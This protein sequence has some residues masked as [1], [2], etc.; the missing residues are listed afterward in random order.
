MS[1]ARTKTHVRFARNV[2]CLVVISSLCFVWS[3]CKKEASSAT[4]VKPPSDEIATAKVELEPIATVPTPPVAKDFS[5][6]NAVS[7]VFGEGDEENGLKHRYQEKDGLTKKVHVGAVP[8]RYLNFKEQGREEAYL[9]FAIDPAFKTTGVRNVKI[10]VEY[11]DVI[12]DDKPT[13]FGIHYDAT[14]ISRSSSAAYTRASQTFLLRGL[15]EW[16]TAT[17]HIRNASFQNKQNGQSDV[18]I[19]ARPPELYVR[20]VT[21]ARE[22]STPAPLPGPSR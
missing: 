1:G 22:G 5:E 17:F 13:W 2:A 19:W 10:E 16:R 4:I 21:V 6:T 3:G 7:I 15:N 18:R 14:G 9:Y 8:C 11:F 12:L 20:K